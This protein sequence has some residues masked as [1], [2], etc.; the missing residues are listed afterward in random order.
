VS[1]PW[2]IGERLAA[3]AVGVLVITAGSIAG[4][5]VGA[6]SA[7]APLSVLRLLRLTAIAMLLG[8]ALG[9]VAAVVVAWLRSGIAI[10]VLAVFAAASYLLTYLVQ[11]FTWPGWVSKLSVFGAFGRPYLELPT[12][13]G[14]TFLCALGLLSPPPPSRAA[15]RRWPE[16]RRVIVHGLSVRISV[17]AGPPMG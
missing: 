15:R 16:L 1:W 17:L 8:V 12:A 13:A 7:G 3:L 2:L 6:A 4:L 14:F 10:T 9:A 11:L 5:A